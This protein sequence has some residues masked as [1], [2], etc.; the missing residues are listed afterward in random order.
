MSSDISQI[1]HQPTRG[2]NVLGR[3]FVSQP[4][5]STVRVV[6]SV[7]SSDHSAIVAYAMPPSLTNKTS[8]VK[9]YRPSTPALHAQF[10]FHLSREGFVSSV[11]NLVQIHRLNLMHS[12]TPRCNS[13]IGSTQ[14]EQLRSVPGIHHTYTC[15]QG[16]APPE[17]QTVSCRADR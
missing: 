1:V 16:E 2:Q 8:T 17:K 12:T 14:R 10:M 7:L 15:H 13:S 4:M 3:I 9:T 6:R 5:F 11:S